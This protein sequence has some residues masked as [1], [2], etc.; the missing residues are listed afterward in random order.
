[1]K[2]S[3]KYYFSIIIV[4][5]LCFLIFYINTSN[6]TTKNSDPLP[7][8]DNDTSLY[9]GPSDDKESSTGTDSNNISE[10]E[11]K[12]S[13]EKITKIK[14][15][16]ST[17]L[18]DNSNYYGIY[19]YDIKT[20]KGFSI[21]PDKPFIAAS[22]VKVP[23]AMMIADKLQD[24][25]LSPSD[26]LT[27]LDKYYMEGAGDLQGAINQGDKIS[28]DDLL[29]Y[30]IVNSD[31]IACNMLSTVAGNRTDYFQK[32]TSQTI[33]EDENVLTITQQF[34][35]LKKLYENEEKNPY[36]DKIIEYMKNTTTHDRLDKYVPQNI[37]A[38]KIGDYEESVNDIGIFYTT[39]PYILCIFSSGDELDT[40]TENIAKISKFIYELNLNN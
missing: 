34:L 18:D 13:E 27:Y 25:T 37:V 5:F 35:M 40:E 32:V 38:H 28:I 33:N 16:I 26:R 22:T 39:D 12:K 17:I 19:Y 2:I 11:L 15:Q 30:M 3:K 20:E 10:E 7:Y 23:I 6:C 8:E 21:N 24:K 31:N 29:K 9:D 1:M 14:K 4:I 36:Y